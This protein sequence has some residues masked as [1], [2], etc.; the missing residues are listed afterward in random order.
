MWSK[1]LRTSVK[2]KMKYLFCLIF[3]LSPFVGTSSAQIKA[4]RFEE[5]HVRDIAPNQLVDNSSEPYVREREVIIKQLKIITGNEETRYII[6]PGDT[7]DISYHDRSDVV[8][9]VYKVSK[10]GKIHLPLVGEVKV[11]DLNRKQAREKINAYLKEYIRFPKTKVLVNSSGR[12]MVA[13][14]VLDPGVFRLRPNLT[15]MEAILGARFMKDDANL[16]SVLVMRGNYD[17]PIAKRLNL[18]KMIKKGD[19]SDNIFVKPGDFIY[20]PK[21][22]IG[23][24]EKFISTVYRYVSA[25][26]G[27]GRIP[28]EPVRSGEEPDQVF[29]E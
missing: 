28:G 19:R 12:Y 15:V 18:H 5:K 29:F 8:K 11:A 26:Y 27:L 14:E 10:T 7:L 13:G 20:V 4:T 16:K 2:P 17:D 24:I 25:Y 1:A 23:N 6:V 22:F 21:R 9:Q 3:L